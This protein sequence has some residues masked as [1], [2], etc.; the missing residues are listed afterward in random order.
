MSRITVNHFRL[1]F[2]SDLWR[3][4]KLERGHECA[5]IHGT[6]LSP[7]SVVDSRE[8]FRHSCG[9]LARVECTSFGRDSK[10]ETRIPG[11]VGVLD[12]KT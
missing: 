12:G 1:K 9:F 7:N 10:G 5:M 6:L 4:S 2:Q 11:A 8:A 3:F